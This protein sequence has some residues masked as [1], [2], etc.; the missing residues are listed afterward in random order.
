M[1]LP[2]K[3]EVKRLC[4]CGCGS[5]LE[6][7]GAFTHGHHT[8]LRNSL[9]EAAMAD[10]KFDRYGTP[11]DPVKELH[12][13]GWHHFY[14][15]AAKR[16]AR[17]KTEAEARAAHDA[18]VAELT[19]RLTN[20]ER[21]KEMVALSGWDIHV[22]D[23]NVAGIIEGT[24]D[25]ELEEAKSLNHRNRFRVGTLVRMVYKDHVYVAKILELNGDTAEVSFKVRHGGA[26]RIRTMPVDALAPNQK[27]ESKK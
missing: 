17:A 20:I 8:R 16:N 2:K 13:R 15:D 14:V 18:E 1:G 4:D 9:I 10:E 7:R 19:E 3:P 5:T 12:E 6:G 24:I 11:V 21:A 25:P 27:K 22:H 26:T 23:G